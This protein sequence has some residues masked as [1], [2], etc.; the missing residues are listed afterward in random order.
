[1]WK[2]LKFKSCRYQIF[3]HATAKDKELCY[4]FY[5]DFL[6]RLEDDELF[7]AK[8]ISSDKVTPHLLGNVTQHNL[9]M[10]GSNSSR[11]VIEY[12][13]ESKVDVF[14]AL[15]KQR[16]FGPFFV[17][18]VHT[19]CR[20]TG[21]IPHAYLE[22]VCTNDITLQQDRVL[23]HFHIK[24]MDFLNPRFPEKF[25]GRSTSITLS[26]GLSDIIPHPFFGSEY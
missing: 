6:L 15:S 1:M 13:R 18:P 23:L 12:M 17:F 2:C 11:E 16:G 24:V 19:A 3:Q 7:T 9:R 25:N 10:W 20:P 21:G 8:I 14:C 4:T 26:P 5:C 22:E